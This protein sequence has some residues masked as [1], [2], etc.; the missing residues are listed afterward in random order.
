MPNYSG[1]GKSGFQEITF[2]IK[3]SLGVRRD[4]GQEKARRMAGLSG[5]QKHAP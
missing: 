4:G 5:F 3:R 1:H 2:K